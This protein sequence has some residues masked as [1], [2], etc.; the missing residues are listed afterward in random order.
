MAVR[1][2]RLSGTFSSNCCC[3]TALRH[4]G[5]SAARRQ[6]VVKQW[7][8]FERRGVIVEEGTGITFTIPN[9]RAFETVLP[10]HLR[11]L[12]GAKVSFTVPSDGSGSTSPRKE[13]EYRDVGTDRVTIR[14]KSDDVYSEV[15][16][17]PPPKVDL[18]AAFRVPV[19]D[20]K[21]NA[22]AVTPTTPTVPAPP[23]PS[24]YDDAEALPSDDRLPWQRKKSAAAT[25]STASAEPQLAVDILIDMA[26]VP[27]PS[28][29]RQKED[30]ERS[31]LR[32]GVVPA[33]HLKDLRS[34]TLLNETQLTRL[35]QLSGFKTTA[36]DAPGKEGHIKGITDL[37]LVSTTVAAAAESS[38]IAAQQQPKQDPAKKEVTVQ[39]DTTEQVG[40][41]VAWS[42]IHRTGLA[43]LGTHDDSA[44]VPIVSSTQAKGTY[45]I[46]NVEA[47]Q[48]AMPSS[49]T[50]VGRKIRFIGVRYSDL[51]Q[52]VFAEDIVIDGNLDY[53][54]RVSPEMQG[55]TKEA[56]RAAA[57]K[58]KYQALILDS[59]S[60]SSMDA[61]PDAWYRDNI[62]TT[63]VYGV[64]TRWSG[65]QGT[66]EIGSGKT[67][68]VDSAAEF[69]QLVDSSSSHIRGAVVTFEVNADSPR[70]ARRINVLTL[71][72]RSDTQGT[73]KPLALRQPNSKAT[74][75]R[76]EASTAGEAPQGAEW[77]KGFLVSWSPTETQGI[78]QGDDGNRYLL[79]DALENVKDYKDRAVHL[80]SKGRRVSFVRLSESGFVACHVIVE[81]G[82][83]DE[84]T[85]RKAVLEAEQKEPLRT[86]DGNMSE[87]VASPLSTG[88]WMSKL[89]KVG[90]DVSEVKKRQESVIP[91]DLLE[92]DDDPLLDTKEALSKDRWFN[93]KDKNKKLPGSEV[94]PGDIAQMSPTAMVNLAA[95]IRNPEKL[96]KMKDKY[97]NQLSEEM[98]EHAWKQAKEMAPRYGKR[99]REAREVGQEPT[100]HFY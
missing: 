77:L 67:Y 37:P 38:T 26:T 79:R 90:F 1:R 60:D 10:T 62:P 20:E 73:P 92:G 11:D 63:A 84:E 71:S 32:D 27:L 13:G 98:K 93:D 54:M 81:E 61:D 82:E 7:H 18:L 2:V 44:P 72:S 66:V 39:R 53:T 87:A 51:P 47:F 35:R 68:F 78:I 3:N 69:L 16:R 59:P 49:L 76:A 6:G 89:E 65:G 4:S 83:A 30:S 17:R 28:A 70:F 46:R 24:R 58:E 25:S 21:K 23:A 99:I 85:V 95:K 91:P 33:T 22:N 8:P 100:F 75:D 94:R 52:Q 40:T 34:T 80:I 42:S 50:L 12:V 64:L 45:V 29:E 19:P 9:T 15:F 56:L 36:S 41:I 88:Y 55:N 96:E 57:K 97:F 31:Y 86:V 48:S 43:L 14:R 5:G 74:D